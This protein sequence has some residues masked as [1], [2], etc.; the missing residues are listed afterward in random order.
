MEYARGLVATNLRD[1]KLRKE[2]L[3][4]AADLLAFAS[5]YHSEYQQ[6]ARVKLADPLLGG[7]VKEEKPKSYEDACERGKLVWD[8]MQEPNLKAEE[9][10]RLRKEALDDFRFALAHP[11]RDVKLA[12][13]NIIRY[14]LAY[15]YWA[16]GDYYEAAVMGE[17]LAYRY[18]NRPE[19]SRARR[20]PW[21]PTANCSATPPPAT[22]INSRTAERLPSRADTTALA[23]QP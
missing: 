12:D 22:N 14:C 7:Q 21:P 5:R 17:F 9:E 2:H 16:T 23:R 10:A 8:Q 6:R 18:P 13:L 1:I 19:D 15:L 4:L 3:Q 20:S 11:P